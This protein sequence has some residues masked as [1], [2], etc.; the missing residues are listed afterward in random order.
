MTAP[1]GQRAPRERAGVV[2][3]KRGAAGGDW[4][5]EAPRATRRAVGQ[6][7]RRTRSARRACFMMEERTIGAS[8]LSM[9]A[10]VSS[11]P[12]RIMYDS[13]P[14]RAIAS[15]IPPNSAIGTRNCLRTREYAPTPA[16]TVRAA[17]IAPAGR[18]TQRP[19]ARHS[20][21]MCPAT[22][23]KGERPPV[24]SDGLSARREAGA[25]GAARL[26]AARAHIRSRSAAG[27]PGRTPLESRRRRRARCRS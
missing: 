17:P 13:R 11:V 3:S 23:E 12:A 26:S 14:A 4:V 1:R 8:W 2:G 6:A 5:D 24:G 22:G 21:N 18:E 15:W 9:T 25:A 10:L 27:R 20:T 19:S 16:Q 7:S